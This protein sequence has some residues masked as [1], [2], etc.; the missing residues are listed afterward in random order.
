MNEIRGDLG[1]YGISDQQIE[2]FAE[3]SEAQT[4]DTFS[5]SARVSAVQSPIKVE[6][7]QKPEVIKPGLLYQA[8]VG[9]TALPVSWLA[10]KNTHVFTTTVIA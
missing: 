7:L 3:V 1:W 8:L 2:V 4:Y 10:K 6:V 5:D 9:E